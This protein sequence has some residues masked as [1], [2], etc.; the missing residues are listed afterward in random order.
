MPQR[1]RQQARRLLAAALLG[2]ASLAAAASA[3]VVGAAARLAPPARHAAA[4][5]VGAVLPSRLVCYDD[6]FVPYFME[7]DGKATGLNVDIMSAAASRLGIAI[8]F[9]VMPW[10]RLEAE[11]A[12]PDGGVDCA[13]A[14]SHTPQREAYLEFGK[15]A[16]QPTEYALFVRDE[17]PG[18]ATLA[19]LDNKIIGVRAGFR[20]PDQIKAGV[21]RQ[22]WQV[23]EVGSDSANF[24]KLALKRVDAVLADSLVGQYTLHQLGA[25]HIHQVALPLMRFDTYLVFRKGPGGA[26]LAAAFDGAL[27]SLQQDGIIE[28]LSAAY[29]QPVAPQQ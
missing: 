11:L 6:V 5:T 18:I 19:D 25:Q 17:Q 26:A 21:A 7:T 24:Q 20:L 14:M 22:R 10:R 4:T 16:L 1:I 28:R 27:K 2:G 23:E 3:P 29:L 13:F 15:V 12:R 8:E 9:R